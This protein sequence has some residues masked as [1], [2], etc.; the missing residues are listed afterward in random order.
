M[1]SEPDR[2]SRHATD[3]G[4][5]FVAGET[6]I[7][8]GTAAGAS[9]SFSPAIAASGNGVFVAWIDDRSAGSFDIWSNRSTDGG[10]SWLSN[11]VR[12]DA[13]PLAHDSIEPHVIATSSSTVLVGWI[14]YR[15]GFP[16]PYVARSTDAGATWAAPIRVDTGTAAGASGSFDIDLA[17]SGALIAAVW[18]DDR[19][20]LLDVYANFSLDGGANWQPQ[21]Y[22][23]DTSA[24]GTSD[25][26]EPH[27]YATPTS[28]HTVWIDHRRGAGC[29][30]ATGTSC[31]NGDIFYR[32][33]Q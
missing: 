31:P 16:D 12:L 28:F 11:A 19:A 25:S 1:S 29:P 3:S 27:V 9:A 23:L 24:I 5:T 4:A 30:V 21:D 10:A 15:S 17:G 18:A 7:D 26:L 13:D 20:G 6:R 22:R 8:T 14:D 33:V 32:R 2:L